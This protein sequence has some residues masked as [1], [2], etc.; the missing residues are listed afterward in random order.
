MDIDQA[1]QDGAQDTERM[2][3]P[4]AAL[5]EA[6][7]CPCGCTAWIDPAD[8]T[9]PCVECESGNHFDGVDD[10]DR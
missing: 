10:A 8:P 1:Q 3:T 9:D 2:T 4:H 7:S 6:C 5:A